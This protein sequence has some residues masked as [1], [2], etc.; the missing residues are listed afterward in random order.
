MRLRIVATV[1][2]AAALN[3]CGPGGPAAPPGLAYG[4][5]NPAAVSYSWGDTARIDVDAGGQSLQVGIYQS[6]SFGT[7]FSRVAD[8]LQVSMT[9]DDYSGRLTNPLG[10]P[11]TVDES[12]IRGPMIF[13][14]DRRGVAS[15]LTEPD[16]TGNAQ[17]FVQP[18]TLANTFFPRLPGGPISAG[19]TWQ[20]TIRFRGTTGG[21]QDVSSAYTLTHTIQGDTVV[22]GRSLLHITTAGG[23]EQATKGVIA[24]QAVQQSARGDAEG[25]YFWDQARNLLV[26]S[27][28]DFDLRGT[29]TVAIAP[30]P[31]PIRVRV[32]NRVQLADGM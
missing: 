1:A 31:L 21:G 17:Q 32:R 14:L 23:V 3:A 9:Y 15:R 20:D 30:A 22:A 18:L 25:H 4:L 19:Y 7:V 26:E 16:V 28:M 6:A 29:M 2:A 13:T 12:G 27:V 11:V 8:G 5:P 24:G 10:A